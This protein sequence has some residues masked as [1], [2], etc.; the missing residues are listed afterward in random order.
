MID[1]G[2]LDDLC[3]CLLIDNDYYTCTGDAQ[4]PDTT[5]GG[6]EGCVEACDQLDKLCTVRYKQS[7]LCFHKYAKSIKLLHFC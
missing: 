3:G 6:T 5:G 7:A 4:G 1:Q 2:W